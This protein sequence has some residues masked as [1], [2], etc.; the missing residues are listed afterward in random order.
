MFELSISV[1]CPHTRVIRSKDF[2]CKLPAANDDNKVMSNKEL[3]L[4]LAMGQV[5]ASSTCPVLQGMH[6]I[7]VWLS[8]V[9]LR[10]YSSTDA[11]TNFILNAKYFDEK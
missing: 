5:A 9:L 6:N 10:L 8:G 1:R 2:L 4:K 7:K 11:Y 3:L